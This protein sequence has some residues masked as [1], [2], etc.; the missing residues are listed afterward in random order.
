MVLI[1]R[2]PVFPTRIFIQ[3]A[4]L[5]CFPASLTAAFAAGDPSGFRTN[6]WTLTFDADA[7]IV[8]DVFDYGKQLFADLVTT[9]GTQWS[10]DI[11][12]IDQ[13][14]IQATQAGNNPSGLSGDNLFLILEHVIWTDP[15]LDDEVHSKAQQFLDYA[16]NL[17]SQRGVL[18]QWLYLNY[19]DGSQPIY[20]QIGDSNLERLQKAKSAY[21]PSNLLGQLWRG[22]FKLPQ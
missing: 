11:Q 8:L 22:G 21:D 6:W 2:L 19:A 9:N 16:Q 10:L 3:R 18:N 15:S 20:E 17:A 5:L 7:Q 1:S 13:K 14:F 12:P 4:S